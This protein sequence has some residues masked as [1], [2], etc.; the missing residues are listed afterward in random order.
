MIAELVNPIAASSYIYD[1]PHR[2]FLDLFIIYRWVVDISD[3]G[4]YSCLID[5]DLLSAVDLTEEILYSV[6]RVAVCVLIS[7]IFGAGL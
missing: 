2:E 3:T 6:V 1:L 7:V 5:N 4:V